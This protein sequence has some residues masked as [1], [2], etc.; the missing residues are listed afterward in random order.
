MAKKVE[1]KKS[2]KQLTVKRP[3]VGKSAA[4]KLPA[5][6]KGRKTGGQKRFSLRQKLE[7]REHELA[8]INT[9]QKGLASHLDMQSLI[10]L[11]GDQVCEVFNAETTYIAFYDK[12]AQLIQFPYYMEKGFRHIEEPNPFGVGLTSHVIRAQTAL[13]LDSMKEQEKFGAL[14]MLLPGE[15]RELNESYMGVPL[16]SSDSVLGVVSVQ[17]YK[18]K[19]F[20]ENDVQLLTTLANAMS[21][22]LENARLYDETKRLFKD[23]HQRAAELAIIN[24]VLSG[25]DSEVDIQNMYDMVGDKIN[26]IF[27]AQAVALII[28]DKKANLTLFPYI[29]ENGKRL[30][31]EPLPYSAEGGGFSGHVIRTRKSLMVNYDFQEQSKK[32]NSFLLGEDPGE[33]VVKSGVWVPLVK[34]D[35]VIG[36]ISLQNLEREYAFQES[37][38]QLL[39]T[40]ANSMSVALM[41]ARLFD[42]TQRLFQAEQQRAAELEAINTML[43]GLDS[44]QD[45]QS[46]Y[47]MVGDKIRDIFD[48]QTVVLVIYDK[49]SNLTLYP[50]IIENGERLFQD[51]IPLPEDG[52]GGGFSGHVLRT[53]EPLVVNTDFMEYSRRFQSQ[54]LGVEPDADEVIVM[55]GVWVPLLVGDEVTGVI[56]LQNLEHENAFSEA[57]VRLLQTLANSMAITLENTRLFDETQRLFLAERQA[58]EQAETLRSIA[59]ALNGSLSLSEV[60]DLILTEIQKVVP[61]DSAAIFQVQNNRREFVAGRGFSNLDELMGLSFN[62]TPQD[63]EIGY[64]ISKS[65]KPLIL[66]DAVKSYPQYFDVGPHAKAKIR[67]YMGVPFLFNNELI[68]MITLDKKEPNYYTETHAN[69]AL[70]FAAQATTALNNARLYDEANH[71]AQESLAINEVGQDISSTLELAIVMDKIATYARNL[72]SSNTSAI[73]LPDKDF[74]HLRA[75][76]AQGNIANEIMAHRINFGEGI[77]GT[78]AQQEKAEFINDT[79]ADPRTLQI[80]GTVAEE[81]DRLMAAPLVTDGKVSGMMAVWRTGGRPYKQADLEFL[82]KLSLQAAIAIKNANYFDQIKQR[83]AELGI[84]NSIGEAMSKVEDVKSVSRIIGDKVRDIFN[85]DSVIITLLD[86]D[87]NL[88]HHLYVFDYDEESGYIDYLKPFPLGKG[89]TSKVIQGRQ[90]LNLGTLEEQQANGAYIAPEYFE[91]TTG[92]IITQ[93][94]MGAPIIMNDIVLGVVN[95]QSNKKHAYTNDDL[96]LLQTLSTNMGVAIENARLF[97]ETQRLLKETEQ[98]NAELAVINAVQNTL[99]SKMDIQS[100]YNE[101]GEQLHTIFNVQTV[102]IYTADL[103][104]DI[105]TY[106]YA[107]EMNQIWAPKPRPLNGLHKHIINHIR[108][109]RKPFVCNENFIEFAA[110]FSDYQ[111]SRGAMPKSFIALPIILRED[112]IT[113]LS[114]QNLESENFFTEPQIRLLETL[115]NAMNVALENARLFDE[116]NRRARESLVINEVGRDISSTLELTTV[117]DKIATHAHDLL[118]A[119][120]SAIFLPDADEKTFR[121]IA[122]KGKIAKEILA[123]TITTGEGIIGSL[124]QQGKAEF[125]NDTNKDPRIIQIPG[126]TVQEEERLMAAPLIAG[127]KV[128]GMMAVW[129]IGGDPFK[130]ADLEF[131]EELSLQTAI[132]IKN[133]NFFD[134]IKQRAAE[135]AILNN[136]SEAMSKSLDV[137]TMT[138]NVGDKI[139]DIF[140]SE[141]VNILMYDAKTNTVHLTYSFY[142]RYYEDEPPWN[143]NEGG[144]TTKIIRTSQ[145]LLLNS[146]QAMAENN[147]AAYLT[148]TSDVEDPQSYLGVPIMAG[149]KVLGVL[150]VQSIKPDAFDQDDLRL[151]QTIASNMGVAIENAR[152]FDE[153]QRLLQE[154]AQRATELQIINSIGQVINQQLDVFTMIELVGNKLREVVSQDNIGIGLYDPASREIKAHFVYK[155]DE[156]VNTSTPFPL[157]EYA[158]QASLQGKSL[159][160]NRNTPARWKRLGSNMTAGDQI[161]KS[162]VMVPF[163]TGRELIGGLTIQNFDRENAYSQAFV[164]L[165]ETVAANMTTAIQN[166]R[167]FNETTRLLKE[168]EQRAAELEAIRRTSLS[169]TSSLNYEDVLNV[170]LKDTFELFEG[171]NT[172]HIFTYKS[173]E[174]LLEFGAAYDKEGKKDNPF[175]AP[176]REGLTYSVI[177]KG[178]AILIEDMSIHPFYHNQNLIN[179]AIIGMPLKIG[180]RIVGVM[181]LSFN[182]KR[183]FKN[184]ELRVLQL[185]AD[186]AAVAIENARL[187]KET[188]QRA[189]ELSTINTVSAAMAGELDLAALINLVGEQIRTVFNSEL[190]YVALLNE[191]T[192]MITFP[193][194]YGETLE[195]RPLG[196]GLTSKIIQTGTP[197]RINQDVAKRRAEMGVSSIGI[198]ALSYLAVPIFTGNKAIGAVCV[199]STSKENAFK[200]D[201]QRLLSTIAANVGVALRNAQLFREMQEARSAAEAANE[202]KSVFLATM[203]HEIRTPMNAVIGMSGLLL[204]TELSEEQ[205]DY[206]ETI[207]N[208]GDSLLTIINDIL[209]FS[210][211]EAGRMDIESSPFD[212]RECV[213]SAL[214]LVTARA[215][216]KH[217]DTAYLFEGE[218]PHAI[219]SDVT[220]LRQILINLLSNA[221]KFTEK[222]EVVLTVS[223]RPS[224]QNH[225]KVEVI[226]SVRDT[227]IGLSPDSRDR[228]FQSFTQADSSTTRKYG[229]TGLGLAISK[230]LSELMGGTMWAESEGLGKGSTFTFTINVPVAE[231]YPLTQ[232]EISGLQPELQGKRI[233][234]VDDNAT[235]RRILNLQTAK[236]GMVS[237]D[238]EFPREAL[239]WLEDGETFDIAILDMHMPEMDGLELAQLIHKMYTNLPLVLFSSLGR[240]ETGD[241]ENLFSA[242]LAKPIKQSQLFDTLAGFFVTYKDR[243]EKATTPDRTKLDPELAS[244]HPLRILLAEDNVVNQ[245]LALRL[246]RQMGYTAEIAANGVEAV[247]AVGRQAYDVILMDIQMPEMDGLDATRNIIAKWPDTHPRIIGLTANAMQGDRE[248]CLAAGMNDYIAKPIRVDELVRAL[249]KAKK[250]ER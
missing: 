237:R 243:E 28:Y 125:I 157:S 140:D 63:D 250:L 85:A 210:K 188:Q 132:A 226:F 117:M 49:K 230:R 223:S 34:G 18:K 182:E 248:M 51:P 111:A 88:I 155:K 116:A 38:L 134:Q 220:R 94:W 87:T 45:I 172:I 24:T 195:P 14:P 67:S 62:F 190:A 178:E 170:I 147:A 197:L 13:V 72:L 208:S 242:Y 241:T 143:L 12:E 204:D 153:T 224:P 60:F 119:S 44:R 152:L 202:A 133:A 114:L 164:K 30:H 168:T 161:P 160:I 95:V 47:D 173:E 185:L 98:R 181:N 156:R 41:N 22:G 231:S 86:H 32:Y 16:I 225:K 31:Q 8:I 199:Q 90:P 77:I 136:V 215:F 112:S 56:S 180:S 211:I 247:E 36:V 48:A 196:R 221:V 100:I 187:F 127:G 154:T 218:V 238:T 81:E 29:L 166:A 234:I 2:K 148:A 39:E 124:A 61:Y 11:V 97:D 186:Q 50:Y 58:H 122:A 57:D 194:C 115:S 209:D 198:K 9:I 240:R 3:A 37:D 75:F 104:T 151:M 158:I 141:I 64:M 191:E 23:E 83:V 20:G 82:E 206:A 129:R 213:E 5:G 108:E 184:E 144:L 6:S 68:G 54:T 43:A 233:L 71:R 169:I 171:T 139:R 192:N 59:H 70:A 107:F 179:G 175:N 17:K 159:V 46:M 128:S 137:K 126:T 109:T 212:L 113:G 89:I 110:Q 79:N 245:K 163:V 227:G 4:G 121:A 232:R 216:E 217:I 74:T 27:D 244:R 236:W 123:D 246:L 149:D 165:L 130:Q 174:D 142:E 162:V 1:L 92:K 167:L 53:R 120:T 103:V 33:V 135:L 65:M 101:L 10:N 189:A 203:S 145:P 228:L 7:Q 42:E 222:G 52:T 138:R 207:R 150:D 106:E 200:E 118:A 76:V 66:N 69:L 21:V 15:K 183:K 26:E 201:D 25:L 249:M 102:A 219:K 239:R 99:A 205:R 146:A 55:S 193:Y 229:G 131:L 91:K 105:M 80:P 93:S 84:L 40:L 96:R 35:E 73:F 177:N 235:N 176:R 214:D 19:A 78:L